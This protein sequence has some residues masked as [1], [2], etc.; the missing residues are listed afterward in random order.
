[1]YNLPS[2][3]LWLIWGDFPLFKDKSVIHE[4]P[5]G[6]ITLNVKTSAQTDSHRQFFS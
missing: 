1:M 6:P 3:F 5:S 4:G 2:S